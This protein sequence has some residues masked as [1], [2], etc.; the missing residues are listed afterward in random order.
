[1]LT[2]MKLTMALFDSEEL[3]YDAH[4]EHNLIKIDFPLDNKGDFTIL[5]IFD[6]NERTVSIR[7]YNFCS[8]P[9]GKKPI[10]YKTCSLVNEKNR[11]VK[12]YV[13][14]EHSFIVLEDDAVV[15]VDSCAKEILE[16]CVRMVKIAEDTY[17]IFMKAL[18]S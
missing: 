11:W 4:E 16:L 7:S 1:M 13:N 12:F 8:F 5:I 17:P 6:E 15:Q 3:V 2:T 18:W 10:M 14:E 9:E